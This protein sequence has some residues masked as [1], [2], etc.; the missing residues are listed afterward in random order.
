M[1]TKD[2]VVTSVLTSPHWVALFFAIAAVAS[3]APFFVG[4]FIGL[5]VASDVVFG[6]YAFIGGVASYYFI[7]WKFRRKLVLLKKPEISFLVLWVVLT[8]YVIAFRPFE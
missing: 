3:L 1:D 4:F 2:I 8:M 7:K 6:S 5:T